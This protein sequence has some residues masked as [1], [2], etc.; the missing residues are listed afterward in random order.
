MVALPTLDHRRLPRVLVKDTC[1][2]ADALQNRHHGPALFRQR[3]FHPGRDFIVGSP[4]HNAVGNESFQC[5]GQHRIG[6]V[7]H[8]P[9]QFAVPQGAQRRQHTDD[10]GIPLSAEELHAVFQRT[11]D[12]FFQLSLIHDPTP[13]FPHYSGVSPAKQVTIK[14]M[15]GSCDFRSRSGRPQRPD[16]VPVFRMGLQS[17]DLRAI[18][19]P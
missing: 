17:A 19:G 9:A 10:A 18:L 13:I 3:I 4:L 16:F 14:F 5:G 12:V 15:S 1:P 6:D 2:L 11:A 8:L 7:P